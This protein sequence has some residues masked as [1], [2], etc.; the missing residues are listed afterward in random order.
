MAVV[1]SRATLVIHSE[2][3]SLAQITELLG[4]DP[5]DSRDQ[6]E[7]RYFPADEVMWSLD[8][9]VGEWFDEPVDGF[10]SVRAL[11]H[12]LAGREEVFAD[13]RARGCQTRIT[14][15][16]ESDSGQGGFFLPAEL[17]QALGAF[18]LPLMGTVFLDEEGY[19]DDSEDAD[20]SESR[21]ERVAEVVSDATDW[22]WL[23]VGGLLFIGLLVVGF[24]VGYGWAT[25]NPLLVWRW[26]M[27]VTLGLSFL[28]LVFSLFGRALERAWWGVAARA[29]LACA[30]ALG[31][32]YQVMQL[33]T[34]A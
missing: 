15:S 4:F 21:W 28:V 10:D 14:W 24:A 17:T 5:T 9:G 27:I 11:L 33:V 1:S 2:T 23:V 29:G 22:L 12:T 6:G 26:T 3:M 31:V 7:S 34:S 18:G 25:P 16:S 8:A 32:V 19:A 13:L 20:A 30:T